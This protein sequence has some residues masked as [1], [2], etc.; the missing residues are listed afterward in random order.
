M[1]YINIYKY[2]ESWAGHE[3][4]SMAAAASWRGGVFRA[5]TLVSAVGKNINPLW[6][7]N[8]FRSCFHCCLLLKRQQAESQETVW[9]RSSTFWSGLSLNLKGRKFPRVK[10]SL[11]ECFYSVW[12]KLVNLRQV[13]ADPPGVM[14]RVWTNPL[15]STDECFYRRR[16]KYW[17]LCFKGSIF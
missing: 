16:T 10:D 1:I 4:C 6:V 13:S 8:L 2:T 5:D 14:V 7:K 17:R 3:L 11:T 15:I 9:R 12:I